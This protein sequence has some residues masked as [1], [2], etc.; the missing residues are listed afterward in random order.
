MAWV[1]NLRIFFS[2]SHHFFPPFVPMV[3]FHCAVV[4]CTYLNASVNEPQEAKRIEV[5]YP[6][7]RIFRALD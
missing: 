6:R 2:S 1:E 4:S 3:I 5:L 7:L